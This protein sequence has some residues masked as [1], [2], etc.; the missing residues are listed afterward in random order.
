LVSVP[1]LPI[2]IDVEALFGSNRE[3]S[4][5]PLGLQ[6]MVIILANQQRSFRN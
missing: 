5:V 6:G 2:E 1:P 4:C 3:R